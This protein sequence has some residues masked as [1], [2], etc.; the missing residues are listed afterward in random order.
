MRLRNKKTGEIYEMWSESA[1][2]GEPSVIAL[3]PR[4]QVHPDNKIYKYNSLAELNAEWEDY[5]EPK[6]YW[7]MD[8]LGCI[9]Q[10][11]IDDSWI[12]ERRKRIGNYFETREEAKKAVEKLQA[13]T[14]LK[15]KGFKFRGWIREHKKGSA[16]ITIASFIDEDFDITDDLNLLFGGEE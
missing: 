8:D 1:N 14:R 2:I 13:I 10:D 11:D 15:D 9:T 3:F 6:E 12:D 7:Y 16:D 5:E 4:G